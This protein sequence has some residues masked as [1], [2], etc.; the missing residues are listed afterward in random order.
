MR[1]EIEEEE[2]YMWGFGDYYIYFVYEIIKFY[3]L[4]CI[5]VCESTNCVYFFYY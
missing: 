1:Q 5:I 4:D 3:L 2:E